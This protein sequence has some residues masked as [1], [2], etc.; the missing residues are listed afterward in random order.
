MTSSSKTAKINGAHLSAKVQ[1][2]NAII[3]M[4][5]LEEEAKSA[6]EKIATQTVKAKK[7]K[8]VEFL[9]NMGIES[10]EDLAPAEDLD[11]LIE[12][13]QGEVGK[14]KK[15]NKN[16]KKLENG[17]SAAADVSKI[18][19]KIVDISKKIGATSSKSAG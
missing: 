5:S 15:A 16:L 2:A 6:N 12:E 13:M 9:E 11:Q 4:R 7:Q 17:L 14:L 19:A 8:M 10:E 18:G 3:A 1:M